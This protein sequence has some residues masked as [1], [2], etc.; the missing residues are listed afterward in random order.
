M[1]W[2]LFLDVVALGIA[3]LATGFC[4]AAILV[5][6]PIVEFVV[7]LILVILCLAWIAA[8]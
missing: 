7:A 4:W 8:G 5:R 6:R 1:N 3:L 2:H